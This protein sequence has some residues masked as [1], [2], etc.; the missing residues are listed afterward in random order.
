MK[1][2]L[3][4]VNGRVS[5]HFGHSDRYAMV[6]VN[7]DTRKIE[8]I[9]LLVPPPHHPGVLPGWLRGEGADV[10]IAASMGSRAQQLLAESGIE[11]VLGA[12]E[13]IPQSVVASYLEGTLEPG[14]NLCDH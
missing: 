14:P 11:V 9:D 7:D 13:D 6:E 4:L 5:R 3:P 12:E 8:K 1:I 10:V 2:A